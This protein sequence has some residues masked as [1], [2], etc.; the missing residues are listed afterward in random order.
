[1]RQIISNDG[2][3]ENDPA[4]VGEWLE[5]NG[6]PSRLITPHTP[7][8]VEDGILHFI[9]FRTVDAKGRAISTVCSR[10]V[11]TPWNGT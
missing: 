5:A 1:M 10:P 8:Y 9:Q 6:V 4:H 11:S 3:P 2:V 7:V